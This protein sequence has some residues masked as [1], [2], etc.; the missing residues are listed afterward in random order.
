MTDMSARD[1]FEEFVV[2]CYVDL[3]RVLRPSLLLDHLRQARLINSSEYE[4]LQSASLDEE[5]RSRKLLNS[6]LPLKEKGA[7]KKFCDVLLAVE[8]QKYIVEK[9]LERRGF[10]RLDVEDFDQGTRRKRSGA[11]EEST[12]T[13]KR[14]KECTISPCQSPVAGTSPITTAPFAGENLPSSQSSK[15]NQSSSTSAKEQE[16][17]SIALAA[18]PRDEEISHESHKSATFIFKSE[19][20]SL[21]KENECIGDIIKNLCV[22]CFKVERENVEFTHGDVKA[23]LSKFK[24]GY[25]VFSD[26]DT[27][28]AI[29]IVK[30]VDQKQVEAKRDH[31]ESTIA[32][33]LK[34]VDPCLKVP[35]DAVKVL[36]VITKCTL[37]VLSLS[38]SAFVALLCVMGDTEQRSSFGERLQQIL[39]GCWK[40]VARLGGLP[41][42]ELFNN[43]TVDVASSSEDEGLL[44]VCV[45]S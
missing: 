12:V 36:E 44:S 7:Y 20:Y 45:L 4:E 32:V 27:K 25:P 14:A 13:T 6:I 1:E 23:F 39:P 28:L 2:P 3:V 19:H 24:F 22:V 16:I 38:S 5:G 8:G 30:G 41:P 37:I 17:S 42:L 43:S 26:V 35:S 21:I 40:V 31:L 18:S 10:N 33:L 29:L 34:A 11:K 15:A 9:I